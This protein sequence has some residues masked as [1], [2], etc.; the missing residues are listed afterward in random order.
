MSPSIHS[1][2]DCDFHVLQRAQLARLQQVALRNAMA[3]QVLAQV[4]VFAVQFVHGIASQALCIVKSACASGSN[5]EVGMDVLAAVRKRQDWT[6]LDCLSCSVELV[7]NAMVWCRHGRAAT[8]PC[9]WPGSSATTPGSP[10]SPSSADER[11]EPS[12]RLDAQ[13]SR[14]SRTGRQGVG[15]SR[16]PVCDSIECTPDSR[17]SLATAEK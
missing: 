16:L 13:W 4:R 17:P 8:P 2:I 11:A 7:P 3:L 1:R 5:C 10:S 6:R 9:A 14:W 15:F 12:A